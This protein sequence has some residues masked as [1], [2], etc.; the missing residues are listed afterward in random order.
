QP[1]QFDQQAIGQDQ[2]ALINTFNIAPGWTHIFNPSTVLTTNGFVRQDRYHYFPSAD[3]FAD[4]PATLAQNR[5]LTN[6]GLRSDLSYVKGAHNIK[7]GGQ[8]QHW[9]LTEKFKLGVTDPKFNPVCFADSDLTMAVTDQ[10][11]LTDPAQCDAAG[12]FANTTD[13]GFLPG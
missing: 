10:P 7:I 2:R 3:P 6:A 9:F 13:N 11:T 4:S 1:N 5:R 8:F 12:F